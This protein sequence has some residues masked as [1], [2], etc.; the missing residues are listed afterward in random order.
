MR[1]IV[2]IK[3]GRR[4][5]RSPMLPKIAAPIGL[6]TMP[7]P[8]VARLA[9]K[10]V[11]GSLE[12]KKRGPKTT[13][14]VAKVK[15]SYHSKKVPKQA[16][17]ATFLYECDEACVADALVSVN[18]YSE[19]VDESIKGMG[20]FL[21]GLTPSSRTFSAVRIRLPLPDFSLLKAS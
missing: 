7:T 12:G 2:I 5:M 15:K 16:A 17:I 4:P 10:P 3:T 21:L 13:A 11:L 1:V 20:K 6:T 8:K 19:S 14:R 9:N 18:F